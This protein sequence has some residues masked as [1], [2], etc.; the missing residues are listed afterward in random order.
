MLDLLVR[1][2]KALWDLYELPNSLVG[3]IDYVDH[4]I[5]TKKIKKDSIRELLFKFEECLRNGSNFTNHT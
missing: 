3:Q 1:A 5:A 4:V 2:K